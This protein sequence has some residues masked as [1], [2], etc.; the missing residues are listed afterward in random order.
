MLMGLPEKKQRG[1]VKE[2]K[3]ELEDIW[4]QK[5]ISAFIGDSA[6]IAEIESVRSHLKYQFSDRLQNIT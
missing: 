5:D 6:R 2:P 1:L 4:A 3:L